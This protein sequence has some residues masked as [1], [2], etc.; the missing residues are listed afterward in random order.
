MK[1]YLKA[2]VLAAA[3]MFVALLAVFEIVPESLAQ[4]APLAVLPFILT[5]RGS[6]ARFQKGRGA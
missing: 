3:A 4:F 1:P 5:G 2:L 6:C